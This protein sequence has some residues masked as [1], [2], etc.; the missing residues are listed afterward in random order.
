[1]QT[2]LWLW[3]GPNRALSV[4]IITL[5]QGPTESMDMRKRKHDAVRT[6]A[7]PYNAKIPSKLRET[8]F[9]SSPDDGMPTSSRESSPL[10]HMQS[11][12]PLGS[13]TTDQ[14]EVSS[15]K[16]RLTE[17]EPIN[18]FDQEKPAPLSVAALRQRANNSSVDYILGMHRVHANAP[19]EPNYR[20]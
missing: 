4:F 3:L 7:S 15:K 2:T 14:F 6:N 17:E 10:S 13:P 5:L 11:I 9:N 8:A 19:N 12:L 18:M 1:M 16:A 20:W